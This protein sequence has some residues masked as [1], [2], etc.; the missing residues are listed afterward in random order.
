MAEPAL[1]DDATR[2]RVRPHRPWKAPQGYR[3][4]NA[5]IVVGRV[6]K[7][8]FA[9][10]QIFLRNFAADQHLNAPRVLRH[11][12]QSDS[13][14]RSP[15]R[16]MPHLYS[17]SVALLV[18]SVMS[19]MIEGSQ[20][21]YCRHL[22]CAQLQLQPALAN[23]IATPKALEADRGWDPADFVRRDLSRRLERACWC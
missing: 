8:R 9:A 19:I 15:R 12:R 16:A 5:V 6:Q 11:R 22:D 4:T 10:D 13:A 20:P 2:P 17:A 18:L 14:W 21:W 1:T 7:I 23:A 3:G